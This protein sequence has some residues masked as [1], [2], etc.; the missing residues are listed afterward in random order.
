MV[1]AGVSLHY[2][3][4]QASRAI[5]YY[6]DVATEWTLFKKQ[7]LLFLKATEATG[8]AED[9]KIAQLMNVIGAEALS[10]YYTFKLGPEENLT[11]D[12]VINAFEAHFT[13][14]TNVVYQRY[15]FFRRSQ[16]D[17]ESF[18]SFLTDLRKLAI[19]CD[20]GD[21]ESNLIRDRIVMGIND[22]STQ[23]RLIRE[24]NVKLD[25]AVKFC[26]LIESSREHVSNITKDK[27]VFSVNDKSS[28]TQ[29]PVIKEEV[30]HEVGLRQRK[31]NQWGPGSGQ[32]NALG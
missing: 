15:L 11:L 32:F 18:N 4:F 19:S 10:V 22:N 31:G 24:T 13:P 26:R 23:E 17:G 14:N 25:D 7:F 16:A 9:V 29:A 6:E 3:K 12:Q 8:K 5:N 20:F 1:T 27:V 2:D 21:Q 28:T 30:V